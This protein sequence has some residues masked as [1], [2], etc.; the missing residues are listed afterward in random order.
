MQVSLFFFIILENNTARVEWFK[1]VI[2]QFNGAIEK[3]KILT[4]MFRMR[5]N[6]RKR[7]FTGGRGD[8]RGR[9][10]SPAFL[11]HVVDVELN[12]SQDDVVPRLHLT[13]AAKNIN[14]ELKQK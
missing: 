10:G 9:G 4:S 13:M 3:H 7:R 2:L 6:E 8:G 11:D 1:L 12:R 5:E 14:A